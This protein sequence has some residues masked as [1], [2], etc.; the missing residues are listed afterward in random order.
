MSEIWPIT[1]LNDIESQCWRSMVSGS[2]NR[3][4]P[5]HTVAI[6]T[7]YQGKPH[8]MTVV[9][10]RVDAED[11]KLYLHTDARS[12]KVGHIQKH[13]HISWLGLDPD[14]KVQIRFSGK[15]MVHIEDE[16]AR[17]QW[18]RTGH[19]SRRAYMLEPPGI[20]LPERQELEAPLKGFHYTDD[21]SESG[22]R[23]FAVISCDVDWMDWYHLHH[24]GNL[25]AEFHYEGSLLKGCNWLSS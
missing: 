22:F 9:L 16:L 17:E 5:F 2:T 18:D 25:R 4:S 15:A 24:Q 10:R 20:L 13:P 12:P 3:R 7:I 23:N 14:E 1:D 8:L 21:E 19:H 6:S 11:R